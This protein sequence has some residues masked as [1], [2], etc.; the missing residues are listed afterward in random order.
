MSSGVRIRKLSTGIQGLDAVLGGG[1]PEFSFNLIAGGPGCG[2]TTLAHQFMFANATDENRAL[3][4]TI[5]GEPPI[6]MLRYQQ[7]FAFFDASKVGDA[8]RFVH[9]GKEML[10][11]GLDRVLERITREIDAVEART[12]LVD[13]FRSFARSA[14]AVDGRE[15]QM[16]LERFVQLL[17][18]QLTAC[19]A[20]TFLVGEYAEQETDSNPIFTVADGIVWL[21]Q[22]VI[23]NSAVRRVQVMKMRGAAPVP[24]L[25]T[26]KL[27]DDGMRVFPRL[28]KPEEWTATRRGAGAR[29]KTGIVGLDEMLHGG[30]PA[31]YSMLVAG[32]SGSG[33]SMLA[34]QFILEGV[35]AGEPAVL[36]IFEKRP[37]EYLRTVP[38]GPE[39][40]R[41]IAAD[42]MKL[43]YIR[44]LDLSVDEALEE[45]QDAIIRL[46]A[47]RVVIDSLSGFEL[48]LAPPF[49]EDFRESLYRMVGA[50][51]SMGVTLLM[52]VE[53]TESFT[54]LRFSPQGASFLTD[55][56]ILQR[57]VE[58]DGSLRKVM[59]VVKMRASDHSKELRE[60]R[61]SERGLEVGGV[62]RGPREVF[63][64]G[65][66]AAS[67]VKPSKR[68]SP[69]AAR[70]IRAKAKAKRRI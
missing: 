29:Q 55:G 41:L 5:F 1:V 70:G 21:Y 37:D 64:G 50:L 2:K 39:L 67:S 28:S 57:Y 69:P 65:L 27:T 16:D 6:K 66:R 63:A 30:I 10:D 54:E 26:I 13:S 46:G 53:L 23:R 49:S 35:R 61:I 4:F 44:P 52:T 9:L 22:T 12:V 68:A 36:A 24:G 20:T 3:Y 8:I 14:M 45:L 11:G 32:P 19:E 51:T 25:H 31:G 17:A 43:V 7:Q 58:V 48:A 62:F 15:E 60:Y 34:T 18:L 42:K 47:K 38:V 56:I 40:E 59:T 33:K